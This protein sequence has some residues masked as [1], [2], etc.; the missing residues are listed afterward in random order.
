MLFACKA[1]I[2]F[3]PS[4]PLSANL[5]KLKIPKWGSRKTTK[6]ERKETEKIG[7]QKED[8]NILF[9]LNSAIWIL[10][11]VFWLFLYLLYENITY[12]NVIVEPYHIIGSIRPVNNLMI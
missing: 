2:L 6:K 3:L 5:W 11:W 8:R 7:E 10:F 4:F 1:L 12:F 9:T